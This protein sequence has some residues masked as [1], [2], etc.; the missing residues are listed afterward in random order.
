MGPVRHPRW[1]DKP[2]KQVKH[3]QSVKLQTLINQSN[4][5]EAYSVEKYNFYIIKKTNRLFYIKKRQK[6]LNIQNNKKY[7]YND[8]EHFLLK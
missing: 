4:L 7:I 3:C 8:L 5:T 1:F 2:R 6:T